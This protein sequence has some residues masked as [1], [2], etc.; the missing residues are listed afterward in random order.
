M[1]YDPITKPRNN[2][3]TQFP[4][5]NGKWQW[6]F[7]EHIIYSESPIRSMGGSADAITQKALVTPVTLAIARMQ[8]SEQ[9]YPLTSS[10]RNKRAECL[11]HMSP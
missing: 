7:L 1:T 10:S 3:I 8:Y 11:S 9:Q 6:L 4:L 2:S 5:I